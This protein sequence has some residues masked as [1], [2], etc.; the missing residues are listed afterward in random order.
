MLIRCLSLITNNY[1]SEMVQPERRTG[2]FGIL[3]GC[4]MFGT[5]SGYLCKSK[6]L[7]RRRDARLTQG[8]SWRDGR[9]SSRN[10]I[11]ISSGM[12][13]DDHISTILFFFHSQ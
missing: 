11:T 5:A 3:Q 13:L 8:K 7:P 9:R 10:S 12:R 2:A 6:I 1:A 4:V